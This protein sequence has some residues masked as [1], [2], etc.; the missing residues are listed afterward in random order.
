MNKFFKNFLVA[1]LVAVA[2]YNVYE[3]HVEAGYSDVV[4][5]NVEALA[6]D[7]YFLSDLNANCYWYEFQDCYYMIVQPDGNTVWWHSNF[8]ER[9]W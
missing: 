3:S 9:A 8:D 4:L 2:G 1:V 6:D 5:T 7:E